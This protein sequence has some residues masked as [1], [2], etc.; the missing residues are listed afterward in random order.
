MSVK[1]QGVLAVI[2]AHNE[3]EYVKLSVQILLN[4][5]KDTGSEILVI[6]NYS[7]DGLGEWLMQQAQVSYVISDEKMEG[8]GQVL[9][10][11]RDQFLGDR[12]LLL[13][14]ANYF[15]TPGSIACMVAALHSREHIAAVGP[16][17][18]LLPGE[19]NCF[20]GNTYAEAVSF[21]SKREEEI[22][23][24]AYLDMD[25]MLIKGSTVK[26]L[27]IG[28]A[29]PQAV[30]RG[31]MKNV[32]KQGFHFAVAKQAVCFAVRA[33]DDETYRPLDPELYK[34]EKVHQL[35]YSFGDITYKGV[36]LYKYLEP[37]ILVGINNH[38]KLQN[39]KRNIGI[40]MWNSD[41][42]QLST[43]EEAERT[44]VM[45]ENLPKKDVLFVSLLLRRMYQDECIHTAMETFISSLNE[46]QYLDIEYVI[47][48]VSDSQQN[49]PTKNRYPVQKSTI[50]KLFGTE[51]VDKQELL[52]FLWLH[53]IQPLELTLNIKFEED[54]LAH[55]LMKASYLLKERI[56][57][58]KFY[59][60]VIEQVEPK[61]IIYSHGQDMSL[62]YL[63]D[64]AL[65]LGIPTLEI[66]HGVGT[67]DTY[68]KHLVYADYLIVYSEIVAAKCR[69]LGNDKV[70]GIGKPGVYDN[71]T[72]PEYPYPT[73]V[74]SFISS[75]E[76]EIFDYAKNL[77][78]RLDKEKYLIVYKAHS[79]ELWKDEEMQQVEEEL[80]NFKFMSGVLDIRDIVNL[81][82]IV[83]GIR[84]SG[85]FDAMPNSMVKIIA[86]K[87]KA[88]NF[89]EAKPN[90]ILQEV[91]NHDEV[92][93]AD[94]EEQLYQEVLNY[95]RGI[96]YR[97]KINSFW[98]SDAGE[99]FRKLVESYLS[100]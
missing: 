85:I 1:N 45:I 65:E 67:V 52:E 50:P 84:S 53:F 56:G 91:L 63:R 92:I 48:L 95:Q 88:Q 64:T 75:L 86:I 74:I 16:I 5:L 90:E 9:E 43:D 33:T 13:S 68:H 37:D 26:E 59:Q 42:I 34:R 14:R 71:I 2:I 38:N 62:T 76:N 51:E 70:L 81:S 18:N 20:P 78:K 57:Y 29:I 96:R 77:A 66:D 58:M 7:N 72:K 32:L 73:I 46:E 30:L 89:S 23:E 80:G 94:D 15:F 83:V 4:D 35:L 41:D 97:N 17:G 99:R 47:D 49:I 25:V 11:V 8:F 55:C 87:D 100:L 10:V 82:D 19:Q 93:M 27:E 98:P 36:H 3:I 40:L 60:K 44:R 79:A 31:Y 61:V 6:D 39:T 28:Y 24:T 22:F 69:E 12:D 21:Q 54:I